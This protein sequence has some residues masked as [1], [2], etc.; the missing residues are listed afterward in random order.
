MKTPPDDGTKTSEARSPSEAIGGLLLQAEELREYVSCYLLAKVEGLK[1]RIYSMVLVA[2]LVFLGAVGLAALVATGASLLVVGLARGLATL[3]VNGP[4]VADVI[5]GLSLL[6]VL[7]IGLY[8]AARGGRYFLF[9]AA[10]RKL[11]SHP[12]RKRERFHG[13]ASEPRSDAA[14]SR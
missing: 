9:R 6:G 7:A 10:V 5:V 3:F 2:I 1:S 4:W 12:A 14:A 11:E 13:H 8:A